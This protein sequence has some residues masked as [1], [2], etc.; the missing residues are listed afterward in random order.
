[1]K[2]LISAVILSLLFFSCVNSNRF[3]QQKYTNLKSQNVKVSSESEEDFTEDKT[4]STDPVNPMNDNEFDYFDNVDLIENNE[5]DVLYIHEYGLEVDLYA[6]YNYRVENYVIEHPTDTVFSTPNQ[7]GYTIQRIIELK[8]LIYININRKIYLLDK[9]TYNDSNGVLVGEL[10]KVGTAFKT[11]ESHVFRIQEYSIISGVK[12][13]V[14][15][16]SIISYSGNID[17]LIA[18]PKY[19]KQEL[20]KGVGKFYLGGLLMLVVSLAFLAPAGY[21]LVFSWYVGGALLAVAGI[22]ALVLAIY[23]FYKGDRIQN[24]PSPK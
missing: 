5:D 15:P 21:L 17:S 7:Y 11:R 4:F 22:I 20:K 19:V 2:Q 9:P 12:V 10:K 1:M 13:E 6:D 14:L 24:G 18:P 8:D 23:L 16:S 3:S